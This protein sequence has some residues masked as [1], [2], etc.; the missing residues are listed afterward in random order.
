MSGSVNKVIVAGNLGADPDI[1][2]MKNGDRVATLSVATSDRWT[3][4]NTGEKKERTEWHRVV[5]FAQN[6]VDIIEK[7]LF[8]GSRV[9]VEGALETRSWDDD[10]GVKRYTTEIV[11]RPF[12]GALTML[13]S[14]K[15]NAPPPADDPDAYGNVSTR[16]QEAA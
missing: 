2:T 16:E 14:K 13:D 8:K 12:Y 5:F 4:K 3:D 15:S 7:Y 1:R 10:K 11:V 9:F 6:L